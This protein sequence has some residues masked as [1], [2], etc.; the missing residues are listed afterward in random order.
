M[1][2][3]VRELLV[4]LR[5]RDGV[6]RGACAYHDIQRLAGPV[7]GGQEHAAQHLPEP[8]LQ[9]VSQHDGPAVARDDPADTGNALSRRADEEVEIPGPE[10]APIGDNAPDLGA[11]SY[12]ASLR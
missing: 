8:A 9:T 6:G 1:V 4:Q 5:E 11:P 10:P 3:P 2:E 7:E 12:S